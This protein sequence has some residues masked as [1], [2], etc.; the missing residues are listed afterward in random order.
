MLSVPI[1]VNA[2]AINA[3]LPQTQCQRCSYADCHA[4]ADAIH[5]AEADINRCPPGGERRANRGEP[6]W[7]EE[8]E[9]SRVAVNKKKVLSITCLTLNVS[10]FNSNATSEDG[11]ASYPTVDSA[12]VVSN[13]KSWTL[14][15]FDQMQVF[16]AVHFAKHDVTNFERF[17]D[18]WF[19]RAKLP[20]LNLA[21]HRIPTGSKTDGLTS[22]QLRDVL[23]GPAH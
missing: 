20:R 2:S 14:N 23:T 10:R 4:Y 12:P 11:F 22:L 8:A 7:T 1:S 19:D 15:C 3:L 6:A 5:S 21:G 16:A 13:L 18:R 9:T 17:S